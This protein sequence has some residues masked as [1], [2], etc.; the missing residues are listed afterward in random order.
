LIQVV[1]GAQPDAPSGRLYID[2]ALPDWLPELRLTNLRL[3][4]RVLDLRFWRERE[5]NCWEVT[6]GAREVVAPRSFGSD[7]SDGI[8]RAA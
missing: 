6:R 8:H 4:D 5:R 7:L 3:G 2:P 1:L